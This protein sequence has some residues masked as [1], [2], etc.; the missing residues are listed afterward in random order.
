MKRPNKK[1]YTDSNMPFMDIEAEYK[2][3][4]EEYADYLENKVKN[5]GL[6]DVSKRYE[7]GFGNHLLAEIEIK[8]NEP[9]IKMVVN[10]WGDIVEVDKC[11]ITQV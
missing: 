8:E 10:G 4:M 6:F 9:I 5:L 2:Q 11:K 7:L 3:G 1:D